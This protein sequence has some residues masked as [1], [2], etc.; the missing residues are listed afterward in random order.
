[1]ADRTLGM[2]MEGLKQRNLHNCV[3]LILLADHGKCCFVV[4]YFNK[5]L[6]QLV[7]IYSIAYHFPLLS[8]GME[9]ISC[10]RLEYMANYFNNVDFYMY[11]GPAPRIRSKNVPKD[12]YTCK[13]G[14]Q[15]HKTVEFK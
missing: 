10:D 7:N 12:F 4:R 5:E 11:E 6:C 3:N 8:L 1:M 2:L 13:F 9:E 15:N 14:P